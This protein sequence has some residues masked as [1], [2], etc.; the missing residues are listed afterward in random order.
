MRGENTMIFAWKVILNNGYR[1]NALATLKIETRG[2]GGAKLTRSM[3]R[4]S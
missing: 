2:D 4:F 3:L 1:G